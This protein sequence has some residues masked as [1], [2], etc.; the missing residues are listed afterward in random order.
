[1]KAGCFD[2][3]ADFYHIS[4]L[5]ANSHLFVSDHE[6]AD[7]PGRSFRVEAVSSM[8]KRELNAVLQG[9]ERANIT[10]RNFP[11]SVDEL[12]RK[13]RLKDGGDIYL[14]ATTAGNGERL[15]FVCRKK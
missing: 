14:F 3:I 5:S 2:E 6:I 15:L 9:I 11:M 13:L 8:N 4:E 7:F 12:R 1:M 10:V